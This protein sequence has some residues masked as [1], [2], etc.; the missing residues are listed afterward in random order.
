MHRN[1][2]RLINQSV[3]GMVVGISIFLCMEE[4]AAQAVNI[5]G[6]IVDAPS[7]VGVA[8]IVVTASG[9]TSVSTSEFSGVYMLTVPSN[10]SGTVTP[11]GSNCTFSPPLRTYTNVIAVHF[12][13]DF[14]AMRPKAIGGRTFRSGVTVTASN[15]GGEVT[16]TED[17]GAYMLTV[18]YN[19]S[20]IITPNLPGYTFNPPSQSFANVQF[21]D[22]S[23]DFVPAQIILTISGIAGVDGVGL[24]NV[25]LWSTNYAGISSP[26]G[27]RWDTTDAGGEY[28]FEVPYGWSGKIVPWLPGY[29]FAPF[30]RSYSNVTDNAVDQNYVASYLTLSGYVKN[31]DNSAAAD[32]TLVA[33]N[34]GGTAAS[35]GAG[36]YDLRVPPGWS[37][38]VTPNKWGFVFSPAWRSY[39]ALAANQT[40]QNFTLPVYDRYTEAVG[41]KQGEGTRTLTLLQG[42][43][44]NVAGLYGWMNLPGHANWQL[45]W[46]I[47]GIE[48][49]RINDN[50]HTP[51]YVVSQEREIT[52]TSSTYVPTQLGTHTIRF[53]IN[54]SIPGAMMD[55]DQSNDNITT[56]FTVVSNLT[57]WD[58]GCQDI[59]GGWRRLSWFGDYVP[60]GGAGWIWHNKHG[61]LY[62]PTSSTPQNIWLYAQDMGWLYTENALYPFL[63]RASPS[64]WLWYNGSTNPRWFRD[65]TTGQW[66]SRP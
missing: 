26:N 17:T 48:F 63:Y 15:G 45:I 14:T 46:Y 31:F 51:T 52:I 32:V 44:Y 10:W 28:T 24:A 36:F 59:G 20:G 47:D 57:P 66:E 60:M 4:P 1:N 49:E 7:S 23:Y 12:L 27:V 37:G 33:N 5:F 3:R 22:L 35:D 56:T 58:F 50:N 34:G 21:S 8:G 13:E 38:T 61:F 11:T 62:V 39:T 53:L 65:M 6:T 43:A 64:A 19:W 41:F 25:E 2:W 40:N 54:T 55:T 42:Q 29:S 18:P 9:G 30:S 16:T